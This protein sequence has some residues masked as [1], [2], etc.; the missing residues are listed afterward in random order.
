MRPRSGN[1]SKTSTTTGVS[2]A[3]VPQAVKWEAKKG[4]YYPF[5]PTPVDAKSGDEREVLEFDVTGRVLNSAI[6][7]SFCPL[8]SIP[9]RG[10]FYRL[11]DSSKNNRRISPY[12][13]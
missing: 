10:R 2:D 12:T 13:S 5:P 6:P 1:S 8:R 3:L 7:R 4:R 11:V 9:N